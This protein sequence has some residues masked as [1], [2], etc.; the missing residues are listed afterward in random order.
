M[1]LARLYPRLLQDFVVVGGLVTQRRV[2]V[3]LVV[4]LHVAVDV[5][6]EGVPRFIPSHAVLDHD[7]AVFPF[8][9]LGETR[10]LQAAVVQRSGHAGFG[11]DLADHE[12][13]M[14]VVGVAVRQ[15]DGQPIGTAERLQL[16]AADFKHLL[17]R[18]CLAGR[19]R[20]HEMRVRLAQFPAAG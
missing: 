19:P 3:G 20:R 11:V 1:Q 18:R 12:V 15:R 8:P 5:R 9:L 7:A 4:L 14:G 16:G 2:G 10:Q 13:E 17:A 6:R